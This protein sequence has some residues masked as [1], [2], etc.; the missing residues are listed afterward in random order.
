MEKTFTILKKRELILQKKDSQ[1]QKLPEK[2]IKRRNNT[3]YCN[4]WFYKRHIK[5]SQSK[6]AKE[7][8]PFEPTYFARE[9]GSRIKIRG[10]KAYNGELLD[11]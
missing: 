11:P 8:H 7:I 10:S 9:N 5:V 6:G 2:R 4:V 1:A 3:E